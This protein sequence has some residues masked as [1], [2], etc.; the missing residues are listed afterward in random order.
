MKK[1]IRSTLIGTAVAL[2]MTGAN[3]ADISL[4]PAVNE[5]LVGETFTLS[6]GGTGF[7]NDVRGGSVTV[8]WEASQVS[9]ASSAADIAASAASNGF[10][11][12]FPGVQ[13]G[14]DSVDLGFVTNF[15]G[16]DLSRPGPDFSFLDLMFTAVAAG[17]NLATIA[18]AAN[19]GWVNGDGLTQEIANYNPA[20]IT[21]NEVPLPAAVW[22]FGTGLLGLA[23]VARRRN[24]EA[25]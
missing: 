18:A 20:S 25:A 21:V 12:G 3:A 2:A 17:D 16:G 15:L 6:I 1:S 7:D 19:G 8:T 4:T 13:I 24:Q 9:L 23:G 11:F 22:L 5:V 10:S 14:V